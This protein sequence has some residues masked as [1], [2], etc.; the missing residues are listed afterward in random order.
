MLI[1]KE[2]VHI[3]YQKSAQISILTYKIATQWWPN[4][5]IKES[6]QAIHYIYLFSRYYGHIMLLIRSK[7]LEMRLMPVSVLLKVKF[8]HALISVLKIGIPMSQTTFINPCI[9]LF[10][11]F[12]TFYFQTKLLTY[13][14][15]KVTYLLK[16]RVEQTK[17]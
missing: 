5:N 3:D 15:Y 14:I 7:K 2:K 11:H 9:Y 1:Q 17:S 16:V 4:I 6:K 12:L 8:W 13:S 10:T